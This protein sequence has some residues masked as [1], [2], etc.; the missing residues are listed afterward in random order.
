MRLLGTVAALLALGL[1]SPGAA[2]G[3]YGGGDYGTNEY[4]MQYGEPIDVALESLL[5][6]PE[7]YYERA[8]RVSG[9]LGMLTSVGQRA[10]ALGDPGGRA[11]I[12]PVRV[13]AARFE[14]DARTWVGREIEITGV[15]SQGTDPESHQ[16]TTTIN[17]WKYYGPQERKQEGR[18]A[19]P[20]ATLEDLLT[21]LGQWDGETVRVVGQ[22]R[23]ANLYGDLPSASRRHSSD[24]VLKNDVFALWVTGQKPK[25]SGWKLD[26]KLRRDT[27]KWLAVEGRVRTINGIVYISAED[28]MLAKAPS[29]T[30]KAKDAP[31]APPPPLKPPV[32]VFSLPL[33]GE[34]DVPP[35]TVFQVQF[36]NDMEETSFE[37][38]VGLRYAGRPRPGDRAL[39]AIT[40]SYDIG[41]RALKVD[42]GDLLR[43]GRMVELILLPGIVDIDDQPLEPRP[44][45]DPGGAADVLRFQVAGTLLTGTPR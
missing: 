36:S 33:D 6:M 7:S 10:W 9:T 43:A 41:R 37:G 2:V 25:G 39:D 30:A 34:R 26:P 42:P 32:I 27:G 11:V 1:A 13:V 5:L 24:W 19:A 40:I 31:L 35:D 16:T 45:H 29:P 3:Q 12:F 44:G 23:G 14:D 18:P 22:F 21:R 15:V 17:F 28:V 8:V 38:R 20:E 4:E